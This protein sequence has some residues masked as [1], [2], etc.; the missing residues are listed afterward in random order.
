MPIYEY[1]AINPT[2]KKVTGTL[3]ADSIRAARQRL[4]KQS[5][6]PTSLEEASEAST[7]KNADVL[8]Y[9]KSER[10]KPSDLSIATRQLATLV[11]A[12]LPLVSALN[13]L[14][15]QTD[16]PVLRRIVVDIREDVEEGKS[17]SKSLQ[18]FPRVFSRL[19]MNLIAAGEAS[20][21]LDNVL[22]K[23]ADH[24]EVQLALK[25][26]VRSAL[27]YP[28]VMLIM[29]TAIVIGL[30]VGVI[31][32][33]TAI[34][35][36]QGADLPVPTKIMIFI[37]NS[38]ISYWWLLIL[39]VVGLVYAGRLYY[40]N[41]TGRDRIDRALLRM[42]IF[43][44]VYIKVLSARVAG[45]L[46]TLL[47]SGVGLLKALDITKNIIGN[48]H[49]VRT[50]EEAKDGVREGKDLANELSKGAVYPSML[51][52]MV[53]VG[54][55]SGQLENML[56]KAAKTYENEVES[57]LEGLTSLLE[58]LLM[59]VVGAIVL[60]IVISVLMPMTELINLVGGPA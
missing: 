50:L 18:Q 30:V 43:G 60:V 39:V 40:R 13:G 17:L 25:R 41:P 54:E 31:P 5:L 47:G 46:A 1:T 22:E 8:R 28:V 42:P 36:K 29:C 24:L 33:I 44:P 4:R 56:E 55:K 51:I 26:K 59:V 23:L 48:V 9:F 37:S 52:R 6:F 27:M 3:D 15:E 38:L 20:G 14:A 32:K 53:A 19:Y 21:T 12:G 49:A 7:K 2:G 34:F 10:V 35:I 11:G 45:T 57:S 16:S 58:P